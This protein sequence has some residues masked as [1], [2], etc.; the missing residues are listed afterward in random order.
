MDMSVSCTIFRTAAATCNIQLHVYRYTD[1]LE[2][3]RF[4]CVLWDAVCDA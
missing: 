3:I 4:E 1:T 2:C